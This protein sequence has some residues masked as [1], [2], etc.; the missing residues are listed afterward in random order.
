MCSNVR[1]ETGPPPVCRRE[2]VGT[3]CPR[4]S[5]LKHWSKGSQQIL[6]KIATWSCQWIS[7]FIIQLANTNKVSHQF[8]E[9]LKTTMVFPITLG[10]NEWAVTF[11][12]IL[13]C[14][15]RSNK[16]QMKHL[17]SLGSTSDSSGPPSGSSHFTVKVLS[18]TLVTSWQL[19][20]GSWGLH[21]EHV[22]LVEL[23]L[24][25]FWLDSII[26]AYSSW[27]GIVIEVHSSDLKYW[28]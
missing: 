15:F 10:Q 26:A 8:C 23:S 2:W 12:V 11:S 13:H 18:P 21:G 17:I 9:Q 14:S 19:A 28:R 20:V 7:P 25:K 27:L 4:S 16:W 3:S 22:D 1:Q 24:F 6:K 5:P